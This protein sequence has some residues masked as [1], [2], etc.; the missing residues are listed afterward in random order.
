MRLATRTRGA[1]SPRARGRAAALCCLGSV[2]VVGRAS[3]ECAC[4]DDFDY[5]SE[6]YDEQHYNYT[7]FPYLECGNNARSAS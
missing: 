5:F 7:G 3:G 2:I 1:A 6:I 4:A